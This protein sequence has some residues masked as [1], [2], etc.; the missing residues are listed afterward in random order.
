[1][2]FSP[3]KLK[4]AENQTAG[5]RI[6][7]RVMLRA[8][9]VVIFGGLVAKTKK[10][11]QQPNVEH[12]RSHTPKFSESLNF[13]V[14]WLVLVGRVRLAVGLCVRCADAYL[15]C[16][17]PRRIIPV[18]DLCQSRS[19]H[20]LRSPKTILPRFPPKPKTPRRGHLY[21]G[22]SW[23]MVDACMV[24]AQGMHPGCSDHTHKGVLT[25]TLELS[26]SEISEQ[27]GN[28]RMQGAWRS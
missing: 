14:A 7:R 24:D 4:R 5:R 10:E 15:P 28:Y 13:G 3:N 25:L 12:E 2:C 11:R 23:W 19:S 6:S 20:S 8:S 26:T 21:Y 18:P 27:G 22:E 1:M 9:S 16:Y 17:D